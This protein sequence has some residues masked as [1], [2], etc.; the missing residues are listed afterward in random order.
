MSV[1]WESENPVRS[2]VQVY[3][4]TA[5]H[6]LIN[7]IGIHNSFLELTLLRI[8]LGLLMFAVLSIIAMHYFK[9]EQKIILYSVLLLFS[10][11]ILL[12]SSFISA[13]VTSW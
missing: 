1:L 6:W 12:H 4:F 9:N 11:N 8:I 10:S 3:M 13:A 2:T 7:T 5:W